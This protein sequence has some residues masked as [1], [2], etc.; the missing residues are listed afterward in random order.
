[1]TNKELRD[2]VVA[3]VKSHCLRNKIPIAG[4]YQRLYR[5]FQARCLSPIFGGEGSTLDRI[6]AIGGMERLYEI[7]Q[8]MYG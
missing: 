6:E 4:A 2:G 5:A 3:T 8:S 7:A 1:M